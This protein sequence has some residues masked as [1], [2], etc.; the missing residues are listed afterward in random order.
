MLSRVAGDTG[1]SPELTRI[2]L[3]TYRANA[4]LYYTYERECVCEREYGSAGC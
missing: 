1:Q 4:L 2:P 3:P